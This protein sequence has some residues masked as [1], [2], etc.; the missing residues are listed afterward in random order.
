VNVAVLCTE[1]STFSM[2]TAVGMASM[3]AARSTL[4]SVRAY[5]VGSWCVVGCRAMFVAV[6]SLSVGWVG[7]SDSWDEFPS[8]SVSLWGAGSS[9][10]VFLVFGA[11]L[12]LYVVSTKKQ[13][14]KN[15]D[16]EVCYTSYKLKV[17]YNLIYRL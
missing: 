8:I 4:G 1:N 16:L 6:I 2:I 9:R 13:E 17:F 5:R 14:T 3:N 10:V 11:I 15:I 7:G 12:V